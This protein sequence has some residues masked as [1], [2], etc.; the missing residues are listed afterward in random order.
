LC[1]VFNVSTLGRRTFN[2][3]E[4]PV[5]E[6]CSLSGER[7]R[8]V[9]GFLFRFVFHKTGPPKYIEETADSRPTVVG[10]RSAADLTRV[11][12]TAP[13]ANTTRTRHARRRRPAC[14]RKP[15]LVVRARVP[16]H[17]RRSKRRRSRADGLDRS[18][19][20]LCSAGGLR[21]IRADERRG[22]SQTRTEP[23]NYYRSDLRPTCRRRADTDRTQFYRIM[24]CRHGRRRRGMNA[25]RRSSNYV[26]INVN[27]FYF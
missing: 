26:R 7:F 11:I 9:M 8:R 4:S 1:L 14:S 2:V 6:L 17:R 12:E 3:D 19:I 27:V 10:V 25:K 5:E 18:R 21:T 22:R 13:H 23:T 15:L 24:F 16:T 20:S